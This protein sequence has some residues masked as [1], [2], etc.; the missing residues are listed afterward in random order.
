MIRD[1]ETSSQQSGAKVMKNN[2]APGL[3]SFAAIALLVSVAFWF[4]LTEAF[5]AISISDANGQFVNSELAQVDDQDIPDALK[6]MG[7]LSKSL[8]RFSQKGTGCPLPLAWVSIAKASGSPAGTIRVRSGNYLSPPFSLT[9]MPVR[10][11]IPYPSSYETGTG[12]LAVVGTGAP[13]T[14][15]LT[16]AWSVSFDQNKM[17]MHNVHWS[18]V[19][20]CGGANG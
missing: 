4:W 9:E 20:R 18:P 13:A 10:I 8:D 5:S 1:M 12:Q 6:T 17:A 16:P 14:I 7:G 11:A 3:L 19:T 2:A 15:A